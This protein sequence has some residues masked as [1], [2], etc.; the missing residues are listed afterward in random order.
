MQGKLP[1]LTRARNK[2]DE[3]INENLDNFYWKI[4]EFKARSLNRT[5]V[6]FS[7]PMKKLFGA[8]NGLPSMSW[9]LS[10]DIINC[11]IHSETYKPSLKAN[12]FIFSFIPGVT[13]VANNT[14]FGIPCERPI[15]LHSVINCYLIKN[16]Y[17]LEIKNKASLWRINSYYLTKFISKRVHLRLI[18][19][20]LLHARNKMNTYLC[21][22]I[23]F[24]I[25]RSVYS[26][27]LW[28]SVPS[29]ST[30]QLLFLLY[31]NSYNLFN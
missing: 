11:L 26:S 6:F 10:S 4:E 27:L 5:Q 8:C 1:V 21:K 24:R 2:P 31:L 18:H 17:G 20:A 12:C 28:Y 29:E 22:L 13:L 16:N 23:R 14:L 9:F 3:K 7:C 15:R 19:H 30:V 25:F